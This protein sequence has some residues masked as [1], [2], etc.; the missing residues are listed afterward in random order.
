MSHCQDPVSEL[1]L[2]VV[3]ELS[4]D[5]EQ[6][7]EWSSQRAF[8]IS[9]TPR[10]AERLLDGEFGDAHEVNISNRKSCK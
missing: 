4:G 3:G 8:V 1:Q 10:E 9:E 6:W 5:P 7:S 2:F